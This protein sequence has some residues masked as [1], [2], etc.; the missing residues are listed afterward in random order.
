M[1]ENYNRSL[2]M[3]GKIPMDLQQYSN[4]PTMLEN[5]NGSLAMI[6]KIPIAHLFV[7]HLLVAH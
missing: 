1:L 2:A 4:N 3:T 6:G 7:V 5:S